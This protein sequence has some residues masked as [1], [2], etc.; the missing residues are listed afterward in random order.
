MIR[1]FR[2]GEEAYIAQSHYE[3]Y[4]K[5]HQFDLSFKQF[6]Q[7][8]VEQFVKQYDSGKDGLW[9]VE[10]DGRIKGSIAISHVTASEAQLRWYFVEP[11]IAGRGYGRKLLEK[12]IWFC[13][14]MR[15]ERI[16]LWTNSKLTR[17]RGL[18][19]EYGFRIVESQE[20]FLS[21]QMLVTERWVKELPAE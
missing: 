10:V 12:A 7:D 11:D 3:F 15:Y 17:A 4:N 14:D 1:T 16:T 18:Y 6:V 8:G 20:Q 13:T 2:P 21:N 19:A 9:F 5:E